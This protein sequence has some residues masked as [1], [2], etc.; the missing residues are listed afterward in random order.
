MA[1]RSFNM[2]I[3]NE[4]MG[5]YSYSCS[6]GLQL[7]KRTLWCQKCGGLL[8]SIYV[9]ILEKL[10]DAGLLPENYKALCCACYNYRKANKIL[11]GNLDCIFIN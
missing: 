3:I 8:T 9:H 1:V 6:S 11:F 7:P 2:L 4:Y 10:K 5:T